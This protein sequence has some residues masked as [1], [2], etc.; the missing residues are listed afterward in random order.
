MV[1][2]SFKLTLS[3]FFHGKGRS[4]SGIQLHLGY[5]PFILLWLVCLTRVIIVW[6]GVVYRMMTLDEAEGRHLWEIELRHSKRHQDRSSCEHV[7][8]HPQTLPWWYPRSDP[9]K[10]VHGSGKRIWSVLTYNSCIKNHCHSLGSHLAGADT[11][12]W[13]IVIFK[14]SAVF[15]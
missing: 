5:D 10:F 4:Y 9:F 11:L 15:F 6:P 12:S 13:N 14:K 2:L 7:D 1:S 8:I 3:Y